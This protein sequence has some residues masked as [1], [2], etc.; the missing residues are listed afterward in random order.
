[1]AQPPSDSADTKP[2]WPGGLFFCGV[3]WVCGDSWAGGPERSS[4]DDCLEVEEVE[5]QKTRRAKEVKQ[6]RKTSSGRPSAGWTSGETKKSCWSG[7]TDFS[8]TLLG[9]G[10]Y[11]SCS[12]PPAV[13]TF[14]ASVRRPGLLSWKHVQTCRLNSFVFPRLR[15]KTSPPQQKGPTGG[16][17]Y[18][19]AAVHSGSPASVLSVHAHSCASLEEA[20]P[21]R[22]VPRTHSDPPAGPLQGHTHTHGTFC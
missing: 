15:P 2:L 5:I 16:P 10:T 21:A 13:V 9:G 3:W 11:W 19:S 12:P 6:T 17:A 7:A 1:M 8:S 4:R 20:S 18:F 14:A 22:L